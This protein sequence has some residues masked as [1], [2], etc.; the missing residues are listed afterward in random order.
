[1]SEGHDSLSRRAVAVRAGVPLLLGLLVWGVRPLEAAKIHRINS[2]RPVT[3]PEAR[4]ELQ[5]IL[6]QNAPLLEAQATVVKTVAK[7]IGPSV[8]HIEADVPDRTLLHNRDRRIEEEGSGVV[9]Q[10]KDRFYV[11]TNRHVFRNAPA[12]G[13]RIHLADGRQLHPRRVLEDDATDVGVLAIEAPDLIASPLGDSDRLEIGDFVLA[14]GSPF[15][16]SHSVTFGIISARG[17][18]DLDLG[19]ESVR[20]QDFLQTDAAINP[21]NSGGPLCNLR[22]EIVGINTAIASNSGGN[23]GIGFSIP[24]NLF[25]AVTR[26]LID[27]GKVTRAFLGVSLDA[28]FGPAMAAE[29]G[30][31]RVTGTRVTAITRGGPA[32]AAGVRVGDVILK[33]GST[34]IDDDA[35]LV[36]L[37]G[38][39]EV[40][41]RVSLEIF[42]DGR[43]LVIQAEVSDRSK[44][45]P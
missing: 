18:H 5:R 17:R 38:M 41:K 6:Q 23:E 42:R 32:E 43:I 33:L 16:L 10:R 22:G 14:A 20:F 1:M 35:H 15:G 28:K 8:V 34:V 9:I 39:M 3:S 12:D 7:L 31:Q 24:I 13:I 11:L 29:L 4:N 19:D 2:Q 25:M 40:G 44:F 26:Q 30:M 27:T 45:G 37:V 21:G 36:N